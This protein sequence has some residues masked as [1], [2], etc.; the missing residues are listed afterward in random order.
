MRK[1]IEQMEQRQAATLQAMMTEMQEQQ[2]KREN[3]IQLIL[4]EKERQ[5]DLMKRSA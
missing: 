1:Q 3:E 4:E 2:R 5:I